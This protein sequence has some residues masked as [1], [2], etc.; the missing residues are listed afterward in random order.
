MTETP[1]SLSE[2]IENSLSCV[3]HPHAS[4]IQVHRMISDA[5][6][7]SQSP[8]EAAHSE[9]HDVFPQAQRSCPLDKALKTP[10]A[11]QSAD[12]ATTKKT[13][14]SPSMIFPLSSAHLIAIETHYKQAGPRCQWILVTIPKR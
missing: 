1:F 10:L 9:G 5:L 12:A 14:I 6:S 8:S 7:R 4:C 13:A 11:A 2:W 3:R